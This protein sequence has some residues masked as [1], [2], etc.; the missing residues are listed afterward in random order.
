MHVDDAGYTECSVSFYCVGGIV[1]RWVYSRLLADT[2]SRND[3]VSKLTKMSENKLMQSCKM[4]DADCHF[5]P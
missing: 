1:N 2:F 3:K 4:A 5:V